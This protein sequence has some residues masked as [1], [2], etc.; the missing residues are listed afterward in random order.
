MPVVPMPSR[1]F[2]GFL[3]TG[4]IAAAVNFGS[5][6]LYDD[7]VSFAWAVALAY[8]TGMATAFLLAR[9]FVFGRGGQSTGQSALWFTAVNGVALLQTWVVTLLLARW[10]LPGLG[11]ERH[12]DELAHAVGIVVPVLSSYWG[13]KHLSFR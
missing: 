9:A 3:L 5:R 8:L 2:L 4:G 7:V 6:L 12:V 13:H 10:A 11:M 1:Q